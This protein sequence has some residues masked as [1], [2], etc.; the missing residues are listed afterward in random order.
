LIS[1][2]LLFSS[3]CFADEES[4]FLKLKEG[5][6]TNIIKTK[7]S[8]EQ[9]EEPPAELLSIVKYNT[10]LGK[11]SAYLTKPTDTNKKYPAIIWIT[12]GFP[13]GGA[14]SSV[15][16]STPIENDQ[17]AKS[18]WQHNIITMYPSFRGSYGNPGQQEGFYGEVDDVLSSLE[19]LSKLDYVDKKE[20]YLGGHSTGGTLALLVAAATDKFKSI[21]SF[22]P[23]AD[24]AD[25][26]AEY[27]LHDI[28]KS[29]EN[30]FRAPINFLEYIKSPTYIIEGVDGNIDSLTNLEDSGKGKNV[31]YIPIENGDHFDILYPINRLITKNIS[32]S[33]K[34]IVNQSSAQIAFDDIEVSLRETNDLKTLT[35][36]RENGT[37][38]NTIIEGHYYLASL[39]KNTLEQ[40][41]PKVT[42]MGFLAEVL[43][44]KNSDGTEYYLLI[45]KLKF[46][47]LDLKSTFENSKKIHEL[48]TQ[49]EIYYQGWYY[50]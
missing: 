41:I 14:G 6:K 22:G 4:E 37:S 31:T 28:N 15:W 50:E 8:N 36:L 23:V 13:S 29:K 35:K 11:M 20:I 27:Q 16:E 10:K 43:N 19:Y 26:G 45:A 42:K 44:R 18:F 34:I 30:F 3:I 24:P 25:Y 40:I 47:P 21:F 48:A 7:K 2:F 39:E 5:F 46:S 1:F 9:F 17:S 33:K 12:G 32:T 49:E 38:L